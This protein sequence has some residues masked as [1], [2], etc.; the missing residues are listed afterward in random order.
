M[1]KSGHIFEDEF[2]KSMPDYVYCKKLQVSGMN[3]KGGGNEADFLVYLYP[4]LY[5]FEL[6]SHKGKSIPFECIR[7]GQLL[8]LYRL[9]DFGGIFGGFIFNFRDVERTFYL[10]IDKVYSFM[11]ESDRKSFPISWCESY[12]IELEQKKL[13]TRYKYNVEKLLNDIVRR[14]YRVI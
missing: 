4:N 9:S 6:K 5:L 2:K 3:Y 7:D 1:R 12:G 13:R 14:N 10:S 8:G 11:L